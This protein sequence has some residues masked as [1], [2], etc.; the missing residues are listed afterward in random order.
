MLTTVHQEPRRFVGHLWTWVQ[1]IAL[2]YVIAFGM[3][4]LSAT[5]ALTVRGAIELLSWI[6]G[7][8]R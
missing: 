2:V 1:A 5:V 4:L 7:L 6:A 3:V 8:V